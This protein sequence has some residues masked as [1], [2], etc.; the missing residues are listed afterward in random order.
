MLNSKVEYI[1]N[2]RKE[3][4]L[5]E[6][7][8]AA[9]DSIHWKIL[10]NGCFYAEIAQLG[11]NTQNARLA[12]CQTNIRSILEEHIAASL[13]NHVALPPINGIEIKH[14]QSK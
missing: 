9:L 5:T 2:L 12:D 4:M 3:V 11:I 14:K 10:P 7:I 13:I 6:Y 1:E 8:Y